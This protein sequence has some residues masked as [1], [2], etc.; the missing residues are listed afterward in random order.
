[1]EVLLAQ[2]SR[3]LN[4]KWFDMAL[5]QMGQESGSCWTATIIKRES[6]KQLLHVQNV[7]ILFESECFP[8]LT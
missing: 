4:L 8:S 2:M 7:K 3:S 1:M 6:S 5:Q